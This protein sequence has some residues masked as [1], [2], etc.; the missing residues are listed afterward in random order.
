MLEARAIA[1]YGITPGVPPQS[2]LWR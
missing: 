2:N 1:R